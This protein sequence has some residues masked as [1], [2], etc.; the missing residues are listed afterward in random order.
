MPLVVLSMSHKFAKSIKFTRKS[1]EHLFV[2]NLMSK[3]FEVAPQALASTEH[4]VTADDIEIWP[5]ILH[6]M[7]RSKFDISIDIVT[8]SDQERHANCFERANQIT[9]ELKK[10]LGNPYILFCVDIHLDTEGFVAS[11]ILF[12]SSK[13]S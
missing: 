6:P 5:N 8:A 11:N 13:S 3:I 2:G 10:F 1:K 4:A 7:A 12:P 9:Q